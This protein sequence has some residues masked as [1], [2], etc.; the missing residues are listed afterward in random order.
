MHIQGDVFHFLKNA[1]CLQTI[2]CAPV[3][4]CWQILFRVQTFGAF[5]VQ[6]FWGARNVFKEILLQRNSQCDWTRRQT[7]E[8]NFSPHEN[9]CREFSQLRLSLFI[10]QKCDVATARFNLSDQVHVLQIFSFSVV[11]SFRL[12]QAKM[13]Y[14]ARETKIMANGR[15]CPRLMLAV[16]GTNN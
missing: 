14:D 13:V 8:K 16:L 5:L 12:T 2:L 1:L 6:R 4:L 10:F 11:R 7:L 9:R 15:L 3:K